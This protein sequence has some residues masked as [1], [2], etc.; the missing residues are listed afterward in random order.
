MAVNDARRT[1]T[2]QLLSVTDQV[3]TLERSELECDAAGEWKAEFVALLEL[4]QDLESK[5]DEK[6]LFLA[7]QINSTESLRRLMTVIV[8]CNMQLT[9]L[10]KAV[11]KKAP[12]GALRK[13]PL[14]FGLRTAREHRKMLERWSRELQWRICW[15]ALHRTDIGWYEPGRVC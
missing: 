12:S 5:R 14:L 1:M 8:V 10:G 4:V 3:A 15:T 2:R 11:E 6:L 9:L 7:S 13:L